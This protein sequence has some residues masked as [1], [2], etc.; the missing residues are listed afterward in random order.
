MNSLR[1]QIARRASSLLLLALAI[2]LGGC[3]SPESPGV[4]KDS[5]PSL[6][7]LYRLIDR[8]D[9]KSLFKLLPEDELKE[10]KLS[11]ERLQAIIDLYKDS[12]AGASF[13]PPEITTDSSGIILGNQLI[14]LENGSKTVLSLSKTPRYNEKAKLSLVTALIYC[15]ASAVAD[16]PETK[17]FRSG[18]DYRKRVANGFEELIP[19]LRKIGVDQICNSKCQS[20]SEELTLMQ[21][22]VKRLEKGQPVAGS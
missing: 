12:V 2:L 22:R 20:L 19:R 6:E 18:L 3:Q 16:S 13:D 21:N 10:Y 11:E 7:E 14:T 17:M 5:A 1:V 4:A 8:G 9:A 15:S